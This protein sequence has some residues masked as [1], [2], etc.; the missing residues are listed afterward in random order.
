MSWL[1]TRHPLVS[2]GCH[3][4]HF[5]APYDQWYGNQEDGEAESS[6]DQGNI[7]DAHGFRPWR[8]NKKNDDGEYIPNKGNADHDISENL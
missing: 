8:E 1:S 4:T 6:C 3:N 2:L 7:L 5:L